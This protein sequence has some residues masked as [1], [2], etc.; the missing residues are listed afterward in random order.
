MDEGGMTYYGARGRTF[1]LAQKLRAF[2]VHVLTALGAACAFL[3]LVE[4]VNGEWPRMFVW[5]GIAFAVD[6]IDG[7]LARRFQVADVV[8]RWSGDVLD[9]VVDFLTYA[10]V[11]AYAIAASGLMPD[12]LAI[13]AGVVI[14]MTSALYFSDLRMKTFDNYFRGF[15]ALWNLVAFYLLV[16][17]PPPWATAAIVAVLAILMFLPIPFIHPLRVRRL[18]TLNF[19]VVALW[20]LLAL[21]TLIYSMKPGPWITGALCVI[22]LYVLGAGLLRPKE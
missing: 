22:G 1:T 4:A 5:L 9:L 13:A 18:R 15:P 14:V 7:P 8:P 11:P 12:L 6:A 19:G 16:L 21:V 20:S 17:T 2:L 10:F 3:A